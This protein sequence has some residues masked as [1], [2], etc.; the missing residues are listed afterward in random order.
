MLTR[1]LLALLNGIITYI[2]ILIIVA[3]LGLVGLRAIGAIITPFAWA[4]A[5]L[6]GFLTLFGLIPNYWNNIIKPN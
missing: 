2:V 6:V 3:V 5:V 1:I 4:I